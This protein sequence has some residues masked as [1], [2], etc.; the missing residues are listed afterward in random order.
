MSTRRSDRIGADADFPAFEILGAFDAGIGTNQQPAMVEA[1]GDENRQR[2]EGRAVSARDDIGRRRDLADI[3]LDLPH[4]ATEGADLRDHFDEIGLTPS[5]GISPLRRA[6]VRI[7]RNRDIKLDLISQRIFSRLRCRTWQSRAV[8]FSR[9]RARF[10]C[11]RKRGLVTVPDP[12][13]RAG[14]YPLTPHAGQ[15]P[16]GEQCRSVPAMLPMRRRRSGSAAPA[17]SINR[18]RIRRWCYFGGGNIHC[19]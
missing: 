16:I 9:L 5:I 11:T 13:A 7:I 15:W 17:H 18:R 10:P 4:H 3:E 19:G 8:G 12:G 1:A 2:D 6:A 14:L